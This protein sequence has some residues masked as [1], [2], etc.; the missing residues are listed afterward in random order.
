MPLSFVRPE[1]LEQIASELLTKFHPSL[2]LPVPIEQ[3]VEFDF[4]LDIVPV[5]NLYK[6]YGIEGWLA[7]DM[8]TIH[9]DAYQYSNWLFKYRF[10]L[11]HEL[12]HLLLHADLYSGKAFGTVE[13]WLKFQEGLDTALVDRYEWQ[14]RNLAGR[15]LV[16]AEPLVRL[17]QQA[18]DE[19]RA[20]LPPDVV[21]GLLWQYLAIPLAPKFEVSDDVVA[22][23]L[24]GDGIGKRLR[25]V[26]PMN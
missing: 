14:A 10:T 19:R 17:A 20:D 18:L 8:T 23:R 12:A 7:N 3:I 13:E 11:S 9:V 4:G 15:I 16:P 5:E 6:E 24:S 25:L 21:P 1:R 22:F 2:D 26:G